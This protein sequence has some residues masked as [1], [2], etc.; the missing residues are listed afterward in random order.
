MSAFFGK[1]KIGAGKVAF[2]AE[3]MSRSSQVQ[4][5]LTQL[6][7]QLE[8][9][10]AQLGEITYQNYI[11]SESDHDSFTEMCERISDLQNQIKEKE[12]EIMEI[13][14]KVYIPNINSINTGSSS[15]HTLEIIDPLSVNTSVASKFE[16]QSSQDIDGG[17]E[18]LP[19]L[20]SQQT[21]L[22]L[23]C[24]NQIP[25]QAKFCPICGK[26]I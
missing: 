1:L 6:R 2:E 21:K 13:N 15:S 25:N 20:P 16:V 19:Q 17:E 26:S 11:S 9:H 22:C 24:A 4:S 23:N 10:F 3:K 12:D 5:V 14:A 18:I 8:D 7:R